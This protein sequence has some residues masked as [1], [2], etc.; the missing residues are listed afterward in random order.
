MNLPKFT[1]IYLNL[2]EFTWVYLSLPEF[3]W[4]YMGQKVQDGYYAEECHF[5]SISELKYTDWKTGRIKK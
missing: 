2:H 3:T 5:F 1:G 4:V